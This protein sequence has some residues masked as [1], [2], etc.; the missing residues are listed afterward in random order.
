MVSVISCAHVVARSIL[1]MEGN[2]WEE[3][4]FP[5]LS[6][7]SFSPSKIFPSVKGAPNRWRMLGTQTFLGASKA[8]EAGA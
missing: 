8:S 1:Q 7:S 6:T 3:G 5:N 4:G 2:V